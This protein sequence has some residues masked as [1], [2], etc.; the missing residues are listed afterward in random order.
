[1]A[2]DFVG[3]MDSLI[4]H[5]VGNKNNDEGV[6]LSKNTVDFG[7][8]EGAFLALIKNSFNLEEL[9]R[10]HFEPSL[11]LNPVYQFVKG[12][13]ENESSFVEQSQNCARILYEKSTHPKTKPGE[14]QIAFI[15]DSHINGKSVDAIAF[16]KSEN[17]ETFLKIHTSEDG[18]DLETEEGISMNKLDKGCLI[19]NIEEEDG[20]RVA[21]V[22]NTNKGSDAQYWKDEFLGVEP[23]RNEYHQT[24]EFLGITKNFV[25]QHLQ[26]EFE[27]SKTDK[28]DFLNRSVDYFKKHENFDLEDF[29]VEVFHDP[30]V[31]KSF[32]EY[33]TSFRQENNLES[34]ENFE[35]SPQAVKK[36]ARVFKSVL[37][38]DKNFHIYI[39]GNRELIEQGVDEMGRKFYKIYYNTES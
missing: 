6:F 17:K 32:K 1:M 33:D 34:F 18:L 31:I 16:F 9:Y 5:Q 36:Q 24:K 29:G 20:Y 23:V 21:I 22:D 4:V 25:M 28:I 37:K 14:L 38:L 30:N 13:F 8:L 10:F 27:L 19:F 15:R 39:H 3:I 35:I 12:I 2:N 11:D 7:E 26:E